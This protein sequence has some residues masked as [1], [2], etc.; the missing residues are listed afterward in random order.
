MESESDSDEEAIDDINRRR[1]TE[2]RAQ[3][4]RHIEQIIAL[5]IQLQSV[6]RSLYRDI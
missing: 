6:R 5:G 3:M 2:I 1:E 4:A